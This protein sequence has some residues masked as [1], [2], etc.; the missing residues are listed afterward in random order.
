MINLNNSKYVIV[1][2]F[3][4]EMGYDG[5]QAGN[6]SQRR[7]KSV[8]KTAAGSLASHSSFFLSNDL[9]I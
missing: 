5:S 4:P 9:H 6:H 7:Q 8:V 3:M 2:K 1:P